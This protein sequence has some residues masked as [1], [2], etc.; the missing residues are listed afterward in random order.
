MFQEIII[1]RC[2]ELLSEILRFV[3]DIE[4]D[5]LSF[6]LVNKT[7]LNQINTETFFQ[8]LCQDR[9]KPTTTTRNNKQLVIELLHSQQITA[10]ELFFNILACQWSEVVQTTQ[11]QIQLKEFGSEMIINKCQD[12]KCYLSQIMDDKS[13]HNFLM[14]ETVQRHI[15]GK[16]PILN[17]IKVYFHIKYLKQQ[18]I[19]HKTLNLI[20]I[21]IM[22]ANVFNF[23]VERQGLIPYLWC[24][25][26]FENTKLKL[27]NVEKECG[28]KLNKKKKKK[29]R[30]SNK[31][32]DRDN[33]GLV[34]NSGCCT[35]GG[36]STTK[37]NSDKLMIYNDSDWTE[38]DVFAIEVKGIKEGN[39]VIN[40]YKNDVLTGEV[41]D[42]LNG[43]DLIERSR[44][45][46]YFDVNFT[47]TFFNVDNTVVISSLMKPTEEELKQKL[48]L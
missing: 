32:K 34:F 42:V 45:R 35:S 9:L 22:N 1:D 10:Q 40:Y 21:G 18:N 17:N 31:D 27:K 23:I 12:N 14:N 43:L 38:N 7:W 33:K 5:L 15:R 24:G 36:I 8:L 26:I 48:V 41:K 30:K 44:N 47:Q 13:V 20:T 46:L 3:P 25:Q 16:F 28:G 29:E 11:P 37:G 4:K 6:Q 19:S 2:P 39:V